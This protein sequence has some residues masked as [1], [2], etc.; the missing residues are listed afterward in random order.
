MPL[1][2]TVAGVLSVCGEDVVDLGEGEEGEEFE[3]LGYVVVECV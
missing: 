2:E 1:R 3:V